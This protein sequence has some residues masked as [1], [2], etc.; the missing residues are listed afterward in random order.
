MR[1]LT[2]DKAQFER[3]TLKDVLGTVR[4]VENHLSD[5]IALGAKIDNPE[6]FRKAW[7]DTDYCRGCIV[8]HGAEIAGYGSE[9]IRGYCSNPLTWRDLRN[10]GSEL[11]DFFEP[12]KKIEQYTKK[13]F[14]DAQ[15][16]V[17]R[18]RATRN[19]LTGEDGEHI[20]REEHVS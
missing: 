13:V 16:F 18:L 2:R 9:C 3:K 14:E 1:D 7:E 17:I 11:Y 19:R 15:D 20:V 8:M 12:L 10:L 5:L 6:E 4:L